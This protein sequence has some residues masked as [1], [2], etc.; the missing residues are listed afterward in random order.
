MQGETSMADITGGDILGRKWME[1]TAG[2]KQGQIKK[3]NKKC[4]ELACFYLSFL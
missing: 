1:M 3:E 2:G 4:G